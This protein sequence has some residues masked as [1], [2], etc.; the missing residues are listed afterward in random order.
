MSGTAYYLEQLKAFCY[1]IEAVCELYSN[2][3]VISKESA[4]E[5][6][7]DIISG[8]DVPFAWD[9]KYPSETI[10]NALQQFS[11]NKTQTVESLSVLV[12]D[13]FENSAETDDSADLQ[14]IFRLAR[15]LPYSDNLKFAVRKQLDRVLSAQSEHSIHTIIYAL[16]AAVLQQ[17][18]ITKNLSTAEMLAALSY[19]DGLLDKMRKIATEYYEPYLHIWKGVVGSIDLA[20]EDNSVTKQIKSIRERLWSAY[21]DQ[22]I[23]ID[24]KYIQQF[25]ESLDLYHTVGSIDS[26]VI[27]K[28]WIQVTNAT[29]E[30]PDNTSFGVR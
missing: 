17:P 23:A 24:K 7:C 20:T 9:E 14:S 22:D 4:Y 8:I 10:L 16:D 29:D 11:K 18:S 25:S 28:S 21:T 27:L 3:D 30:I 1:K 5:D 13:Y 15:S 26:D 6:F 2:G 19:W 12:V